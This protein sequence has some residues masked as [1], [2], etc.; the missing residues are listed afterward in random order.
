MPSPHGRVLDIGMHI[1]QDTAFYLAKGFDVTAVEADPKLVERANERFASEVAAGRLEI[2]HA[3]VAETA[4]EV[5]FFLSRGDALYN[6]LYPERLGSD[7]SVMEC[8]TVPAITPDALL[9]RVGPLRYLKIDIEGADAF[10]LEAL[11]HR[12][13]LRPPYVSAEVDGP[14]TGALLYAAGYRGF[15]LVNQARFKRWRLPDQPLEGDRAE[16][17]F[18]L[19]SSGPFGL[20]TPGGPWVPFK[21]WIRQ[22][23]AVSRLS[24]LNSEIFEAWFD[25]H[26]RFDAP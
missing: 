18:E 13:D 16:F 26:A 4:G 14:E 5:R 8:V 15:K 2:I 24:S 21:A 3:A 25:V 10:V 17:E 1:G 7:D 23:E 12:S 11:I 6:T 22:W 19:H 9:E 20:E